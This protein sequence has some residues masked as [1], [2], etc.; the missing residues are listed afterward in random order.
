MYVDMDNVRYI[1]TCMHLK[2]I[3][4][5]NSALVVIYHYSTGPDA[6]VV[7]PFFPTGSRCPVQVALAVEVSL[8]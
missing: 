8:L 6:S 5:C 2:N 1:G 3:Y 7:S 4:Y